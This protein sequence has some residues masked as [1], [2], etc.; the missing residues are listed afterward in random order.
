MHL[1][2][3]PCSHARAA[4]SSRLPEHDYFGFEKCV[5]RTVLDLQFVEDAFRSCSSS[6]AACGHFFF[7]ASGAAVK[8]DDAILHGYGDFV[9]WI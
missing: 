8:D 2:D 6:D 5:K 7:P 1:M 9:A 4:A 3:Q